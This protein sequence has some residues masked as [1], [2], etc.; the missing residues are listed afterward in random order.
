MKSMEKGSSSQRGRTRSATPRTIDLAASE[1]KEKSTAASGKTAGESTPQAEPVAVEEPAPAQAARPSPPHSG[2]GPAAGPA[3]QPSTEPSSPTGTSPSQESSGS[4]RK[5][6]KNEGN[7]GKET[8]GARRDKAPPAPAQSRQRSAGFAS[9]LASAVIGGLIAL[10]LLGGLNTA[11]LLGYVPLLA[12]LASNSEPQ[13]PD[14]GLTAD[15]AALDKRIA[16]L[17]DTGRTQ[18][19][20][21]DVSAMAS[22]LDNLSTRLSGTEQTIRELAGKVAAAKPQD[23]ASPGDL[24][25][26]LDALSQRLDAAEKQ[27]AE[28]VVPGDNTART[29][30]ITA[31]R[32]DLAGL[33]S[34]AKTLDARLAA[35]SGRVDQLERTTDAMKEELAGNS[36]AK[37]QLASKDKAARVMAADALQAAYRRGEPFADLLTALEDLA[38]PSQAT[39]ALK[40]YAET[41]VATES[42][43]TSQFGDLS[44]DI[45]A[46]LAPKGDGIVGRLIANARSLVKVRPAGPIEGDT[47]EAIGS[48]IEAD[49]KKGAFAP[50][51]G[52][53][54]SLPDAAKAASKG[55]GEKLKQRV[56]ADKL[57]A[58]VL[59]GLGQPVSVD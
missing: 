2:F 20:G 21:E 12:S 17:E 23:G 34:S 1:V 29:A 47:P 4:A 11:G 13:P 26:R 59:A 28:A 6:D 33:S 9:L 27:A 45:L 42:E 53:W 24:A 43:L 56:A 35:L 15:V 46:A 22:R 41:G 52:E 44:G 31:L 30:A 16:A 54:Q 3:D 50:A 36:A 40:P 25:K 37:Q 38:G 32:G 10:V 18:P 49:L 5:A 48:R 19:S 51:L 14:P 8:A 39:N 7:A 58:E 55:W 57:L